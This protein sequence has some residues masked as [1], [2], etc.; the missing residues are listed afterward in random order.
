MVCQNPQN[1]IPER[2]NFTVC[3]LKKNVGEAEMGYKL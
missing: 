2:E 1:G 3:K